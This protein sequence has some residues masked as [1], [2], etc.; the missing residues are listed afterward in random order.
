MCL[1]GLV[2][3]GTAAIFAHSGS[4]LAAP[5]ALGGSSGMV[6]QFLLM[7]GVDS[8]GYQAAAAPYKAQASAAA[9]AV[10]RLPSLC[11]VSQSHQALKC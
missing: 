9:S 4:A 2:A 6:Y 5:F 10:S 1:A 7:A 11:C 8:V 3:I